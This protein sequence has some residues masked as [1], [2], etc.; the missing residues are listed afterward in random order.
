M[1]AEGA[2][3]KPIWEGFIIQRG[4]EIT[5]RVKHDNAHENKKE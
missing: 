3:D 1:G 2:S 5:G 4:L